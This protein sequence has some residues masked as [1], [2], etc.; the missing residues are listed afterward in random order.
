MAA[1]TLLQYIHS[2]GYVIIAVF[3][4]LGIVGIPAPEESL[5]VLI[6][7]LIFHNQ[8]SFFPSIVSAFLGAFLG[9]LVAYGVGRQIGLPFIHKYGRY[10][11]IT[12]R[13]WDQVNEKYSRNAK[14]TILFGFYIPGIRQIS[15]YFAGITSIPFLKFFFISLQGALVW[16]FP[17]VLIGYYAGDFFH[18][19]LSYI[20]YLGFIFLLL[21]LVHFVIK[22]LFKKSKS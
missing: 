15:P 11:G 4:F 7:V 6:G 19:D 14:K 13:R 21:F 3:L 22:R 2:Y 20:P 8:L 16:I 9:M 1:N 10:I 12:E 17:F 5:L 18:I